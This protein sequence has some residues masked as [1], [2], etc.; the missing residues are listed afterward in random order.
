M[1]KK[2]RKNSR[3]Q[4]D[5]LEETNETISPKDNSPR[6]Y[7]RNKINFDF[8][9]R[10]LPWTEKQKELI[11][12]LLDK[13]TKCVFIEG[14]AGVSKTSTAVYAAL[15]LLKLKKASDIIFVRSAVE[16]ADSKIGYLPGTIDEKFESY[17]A[18]FTEKMEE[19]LDLG[20]IKRLHADKRVSAMPVNYIRGLHWPAK[21]IIVDE[22]QNLTFKELVTTI[23]RLGEFSKIIFL[24][25]PY[26]SDLPHTKSGGFSKMCKLFGSTDC[27]DHGVFH[28]KFTKEDVVRSEFVKFVVNKLESL[29]HSHE[30]FPQH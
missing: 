15:H 18:P 22:C 20:T 5:V 8:T 13:K 24:G 26:Q 6:V 12:I 19:F 1:S 30:M 3:L 23:T 7:Q 29:E 11:Q 14:P 9:T 27:V 16:S 17:M 4:E 28:F 21:V 25:D 2:L 10:E